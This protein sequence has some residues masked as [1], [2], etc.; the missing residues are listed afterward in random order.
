MRSSTDAAVVLRPKRERSVLHRHPWLFSGALAHEPAGLAP[1][2]WVTVL[3]DARKPL[4]QGYYN[5]NS[6]V[7]VRLMDFDPKTERSED[8]ILT[9]LVSQAVAAR[10]T[11]FDTSRTNAFRLVNAEGDGL[12]GLIVDTYDGHLVM[13]PLAVWVD[14]KRDVLTDALRQACAAFLP[15]KSLRFRYE[16]EACKLEGMKGEDAV[17]S[18]NGEPV[19][20]RVEIHEGGLR[21]EA[22]LAQGQKTGL[23]LDQRDNRLRV[24]ELSK[25]SRVLNLFCHNGGFSLNAL[26]GGAALVESVDVSAKAM[27]SL[28][29]NLKRNGLETNHVGHVA[30]VKTWLPEAARQEKRFDVAV[31]DPPPFAR[32]KDHVDSAARAYKDINRRVM[33]L[34]DDGVLLT[35]SCSPY[36]DD[37][38][39]SQILFSAALEAG[40]FVTVLGRLGAGW[41]HP[42]SVFC[43][44]G[45][46][47]R[48]LL[49]HVR[50]NG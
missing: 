24:R 8:A 7:R 33:E 26:A 46:Y 6:N 18:F 1:G 2:S 32:R 30:D 22:D 39:F 43:P 35:F 16:K 19:P 41:D 17:L 47:L 11:R 49:L 29:E 5:P 27:E 14:R 3:D 15:V 20:E 48:G 42:V 28:S 31:C 23:F 50:K 36:M 40:R 13:Q 9:R 21:L 38:L 37:K 4:A 34:L 45:D 25:G 12:S 44:E 10:V